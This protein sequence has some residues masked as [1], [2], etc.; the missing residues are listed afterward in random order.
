MINLFERTIKAGTFTNSQ[1]SASVDML[2][3]FNVVGVQIIVCGLSSSA[4]FLLHLY[5]W[6]I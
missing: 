2:W 4:V 1:C 3:R 5:A 6:C